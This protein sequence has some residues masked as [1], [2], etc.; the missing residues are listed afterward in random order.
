MKMHILRTEG[1]IIY[2]DWVEG[3]VEKYHNKIKELEKEGYVLERI[4]EDA[5][6]EYS[7][8]RNMDNGDVQIITLQQS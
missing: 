4:I 2:S 7:R 8:L 1:D 3:D 6:N 5:L